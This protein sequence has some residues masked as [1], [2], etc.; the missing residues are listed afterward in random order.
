MGSIWAGRPWTPPV[1]LA[2]LGLELGAVCS[3]G[4]LGLVDD[5]E[6][7]FPLHSILTSCAGCR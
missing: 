6:S 2:F 1:H 7:P 5:S 4:T 3:L